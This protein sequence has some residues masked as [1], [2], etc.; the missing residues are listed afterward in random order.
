MKMN[1][2]SGVKTPIMPQWGNCWTRGVI[3]RHFKVVN[4]DFGVVKHTLLVKSKAN[5]RSDVNRKCL[6]LY[7][8]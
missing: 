4:V 8:K 7:R 3:T 6:V 1:S 5:A 2:A